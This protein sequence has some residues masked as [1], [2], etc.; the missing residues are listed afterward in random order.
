MS[1]LV[2]DPTSKTYKAIMV[3]AKMT[4]SMYTHIISAY[5][6]TKHLQCFFYSRIH[7]MVPR[8]SLPRHILR[9]SEARFNLL[10]RDHMGNPLRSQLPIRATM[11]PLERTWLGSNRRNRRRCHEKKQKDK[12]MK[13]RAEDLKR[14]LKPYDGNIPPKSWHAPNEEI[15]AYKRYISLKARARCS[16]TILIS[17]LRDK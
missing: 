12:K 13:P 17:N 5:P 3:V 2:V 8:N 15:T 7:V 16:L 10:V 11:K 14:V 6:L 1:T 4:Q 9:S